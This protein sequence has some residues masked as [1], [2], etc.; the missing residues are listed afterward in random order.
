MFRFCKAAYEA[1]DY[2]HR[3]VRALYRNYIIVV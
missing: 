3:N 2:A 1:V